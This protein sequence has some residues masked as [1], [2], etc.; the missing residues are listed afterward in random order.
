MNYYKRKKLI[1]S[2]M[3]R[4]F[5]KYDYGY[6]QNEIITIIENYISKK[7]KIRNDKK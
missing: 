3:D 4:I 1:L 2:A 6:D 7:K 5:S